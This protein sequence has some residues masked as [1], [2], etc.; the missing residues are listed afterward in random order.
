MVYE[1]NKDS[2]TLM[3]H[4]LFYVLLI[5]PRVECLFYC[6]EIKCW[7]QYL[8]NVAQK[9]YNV[10]RYQHKC[11][12]PRRLCSDC[13]PKG[14]ILQLCF[15]H[16][17]SYEFHSHEAMSKVLPLSRSDF[18]PLSVWPHKFYPFPY[19]EATYNTCIHHEA[20][21]CV[22]PTTELHVSVS[23]NPRCKLSPNLHY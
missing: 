20:N 8:R 16:Y 13:F 22:Q 1:S 6:Q 9:K 2:V 10:I 12:Y 3:H 17:F 14:P 19:L 5:D 7:S 11:F 15:E 18:L 23:K 4:A 21:L